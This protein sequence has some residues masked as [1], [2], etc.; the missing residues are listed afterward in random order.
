MAIKG[1]RRFVQAGNRT[2]RG[3]GSEYPAT[4]RGRSLRVA[5]RSVLTIA[6]SSQHWNL[7]HF[8]QSF[9]A[10]RGRSSRVTSSKPSLRKNPGT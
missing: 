5:A 3:A 10:F 2:R 9:Q 7:G 8:R 4:I 6:I 1:T